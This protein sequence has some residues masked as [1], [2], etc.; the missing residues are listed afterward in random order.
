MSYRSTWYTWFTVSK[1]TMTHI[2]FLSSFSLLFAVLYSL[3]L[4][5]SFQKSLL[6]TQDMGRG[7]LQQKGEEVIHRSY[8]SQLW[9]IQFHWLLYNRSKYDHGSKIIFQF[10]EKIIAFHILPSFFCKILNILK[11][12]VINF[13]C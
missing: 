3:K 7:A 12:S 11:S 2:I 5:S 13:I 8:L 9:G 1:E 4:S 6:R 10:Q